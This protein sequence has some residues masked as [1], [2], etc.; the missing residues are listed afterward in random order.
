MFGI[1]NDLV[2]GRYKAKLLDRS[3]HEGASCAGAALQE[4]RDNRDIREEFIERE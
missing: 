2:P 3:H 4:L 1:L